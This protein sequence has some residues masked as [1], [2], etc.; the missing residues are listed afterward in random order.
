M[1]SSFNVIACF[2]TLLSAAELEIAGKLMARVVR[3]GI[4]C[5]DCGAQYSLIVPVTTSSVEL[6]AAAKELRA[7]V[8]GSTCGCH[9][10]IVQKP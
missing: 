8:G 6:D 9:P 10:P 1:P 3:N 7:Q 2:V 4:E 5:P